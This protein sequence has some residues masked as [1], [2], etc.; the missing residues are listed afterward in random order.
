MSHAILIIRYFVDDKVINYINQLE[1]A[2]KQLIT[3]KSI[4]DTFTSTKKMSSLFLFFFPFSVFVTVR[5]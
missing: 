5:W 1:Q 4:G 3:D 2:H